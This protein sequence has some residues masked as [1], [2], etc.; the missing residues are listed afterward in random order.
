MRPGAAPDG[1]VVQSGA[2]VAGLGA[3]VHGVLIGIHIALVV[4]CGGG[5]EGG[6]GPSP[7]PQ[8]PQVVSVTP[9]AGPTAGGTRV[10]IAGANLATGAR[11]TIAGVAATSVTIQSGSSLTAVTGPRA[12][13]TGD[14]IVEVAGLSGHLPNAFTYANPGPAN[15]SPPVIAPVSAQVTAIYDAERWYLCDR[16]FDGRSVPT[17]LRFK[18]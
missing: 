9:A 4:G 16:D 12:P 13:G 5:G 1:R 10:T 14:V 3:R 7:T 18:R 17:T 2:L 8:A 15:N 11:V 6:P